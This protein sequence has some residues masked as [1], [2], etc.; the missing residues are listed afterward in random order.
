MPQA[1]PGPSVAKILWQTRKS[2]CDICDASTA[3]GMLSA[4]WRKVF[5]VIVNLTPPRDPAKYTDNQR[6]GTKRHFGF[7]YVPGAPK[8]LKDAER[9]NV[10]RTPR[11]EVAVGRHRIQ[12]HHAGAAVRQHVEQRMSD[13][14]ARPK[15][16]Q[17]DPRPEM[18]SGNQRC[19]HRACEYQKGGRVK[20]SAMG[21]QGPAGKTE[22]PHGVRIEIRRDGEQSGTHR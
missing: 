20:E 2:G 10:N 7:E 3:S 19:Q 12:Q 22:K 17:P 21:E 13:A 6:C 15:Q 18:P 9:R 4:I 16:R 14:T 11:K 8:E 5:A 1:S